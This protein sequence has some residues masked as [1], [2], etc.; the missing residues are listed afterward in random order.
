M[1]AAG[2]AG[3]LDDEC[4]ENTMFTP[5]NAAF[6]A[7]DALDSAD[8]TIEEMFDNPE[9]LAAQLSYHILL[10]KLAGAQVSSAVYM[11]NFSHTT[12]SELDLELSVSFWAPIGI[13]LDESYVCL[14]YTSPSPRDLSTSRMPSSA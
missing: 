14:L 13:A 2:L 7:L 4:S 9:E 5:N 10:K 6:T 3:L 1:D 8:K 11:E 12:L